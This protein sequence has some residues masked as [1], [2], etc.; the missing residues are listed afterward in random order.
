[1]Y[2]H[3]RLRTRTTTSPSLF[4]ISDGFQTSGITRLPNPC[5]RA[6]SKGTTTDWFPEECLERREQPCCNQSV[7]AEILLASFRCCFDPV[8]PIEPIP[9]H[10][11]THIKS[12]RNCQAWLY[13]KGLFDYWYQPWSWE[14]NQWCRGSG[15]DILSR[16]LQAFN[17]ISACYSQSW[18]P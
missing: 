16:L 5:V 9:R 8:F 15:G 6:P 10:V 14:A 7:A 1:M 13:I 2:L 3:Y 18:H 11:W 4:L 17:P 12:P